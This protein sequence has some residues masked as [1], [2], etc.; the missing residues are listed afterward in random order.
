[1]DPPKLNKNHLLN[2]I[3][4]VWRQRVTSPN[5]QSVPEALPG[6]SAEQISVHKYSNNRVA[7][8]LGIIGEGDMGEHR[9]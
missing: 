7:Q 4:T 3:F 8:I 5:F 1:M 9:M 2:C 6:A